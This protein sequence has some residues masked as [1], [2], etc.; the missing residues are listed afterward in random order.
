MPRYLGWL[1]RAAAV[2]KTSR[3]R[4]RANPEV[5]RGGRR[6]YLKFDR[7]S[8]RNDSTSVKSGARS[9][10][11]SALVP[12]LAMLQAVGR[13]SVRIPVRRPQVNFRPP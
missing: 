5:G 10:I 13:Q 1:E 12:I 2:A 11:F 8:S 9:H 3:T 7:P 6:G 4:M